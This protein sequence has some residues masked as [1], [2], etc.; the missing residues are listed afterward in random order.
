MTFADRISQRTGLGACAA[1]VLGLAGLWPLAIPEASAQDVRVDRAEAA[2]ETKSFDG[3]HLLAFVMDRLKARFAYPELLEQPTFSGKLDAVRA[4][5]ANAKSLEEAAP[6]INALLAD[7]RISHTA[8][9]LPNDVEYPILL[10]AIGGGEGIAELIQQRWWANPPS[11]ES[12]GAFFA[13]VDDR[14]FVDGVLEGSPAAAAGLAY[15]D[16]I[17]DVDGAPLQPVLSFKGKAGRDAV[18]RIRRTREG[19]IVPVTVPIK[20][21]VPSIAFATAATASAKVFV[22]N[23]KRIGYFHI[24]SSKT[25]EP[26]LNALA[27]LSPGGTLTSDVRRDGNRTTANEWG[28]AR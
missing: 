9:Y 13:K 28:S 12:C 14:W 2:T 4:A 16:E 24:W 7:L 11:L 1:V 6:L 18:V 5:V 10:D 20:V 27:R 17:V 19:A 3:P 25:A 15:G 22:R 23:G 21:M 8:L 26:F